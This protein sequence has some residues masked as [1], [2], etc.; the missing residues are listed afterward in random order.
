MAGRYV[1][2]PIDQRYASRVYHRCEDSV[3]PASVT[4]YRIEVLLPQQLA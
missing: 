3:R 4:N 1:M 2:R